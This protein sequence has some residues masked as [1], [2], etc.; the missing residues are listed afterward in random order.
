M[1]IEILCQDQKLE[2][3]DR[4]LKSRKISED[5][6]DFLNPTYKK[7]WIDPFLLD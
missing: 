4:L 6:E 7:L 2:L 1:N 3:I 5:K